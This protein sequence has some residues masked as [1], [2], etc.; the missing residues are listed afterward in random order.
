M[1]QEDGVKKESKVRVEGR[2]VDSLVTTDDQQ[3][4][5]IGVF[6]KVLKGQQREFVRD[7]KD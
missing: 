7:T 3:D 2:E 5:E 6:A 4:A 1:R